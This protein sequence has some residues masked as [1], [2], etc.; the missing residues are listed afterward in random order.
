MAKKGIKKKLWQGISLTLS[1]LCVLSLGGYQIAMGQSAAINH[2]LGI[3]DSNSVLSD[4]E[5]YQYF[6]SDY[7]ADEYELLEKDYLAKAEEVEGEGIVLLANK[8][9]ALPLAGNEK[10]SC[11][12]MG[13]VA[14]NYA[15]SGSSASNTSGYD[16][17]KTA[18]TG[19]GLS[20]NENLWSMYTGS[21]YGRYKKGTTTYI[22]E[23]PYSEYP[24]SVVDTFSEY[25]TAIVTLARDSG[26][27]SDIIAYGAKCDGED[28]NYLR[29]S[30]QEREVLEELTKLKNN[31]TIKKI[32]VLL[33]S[34][35][36]L[37]VDFM[38]DS[39]IDVDACL[40]VGNVG[41][42]GI[43]AVA[44]VLTGEIVP[45]GKLSDTYLYDN[46]SSPA[47]VSES[48]YNSEKDATYYNFA[49]T[50]TNAEEYGLND[51]QKYYGV[52]AEGIYVGY[53]YY[54]TRYADYV[55]GRENTGEYDYSSDVAYSFGYGKSYTQF[56]FS[57]YEVT[58]NG[59][60]YTVSVNVTNTGDT[61]TGKEVVEVYLQKPY[62]DYD[63]ENG[64]EKAA[65]ELVG[66]AK[67][68]ALA[69]KASQTVTVEVPKSSFKSYDRNGAKTYIVDDGDYYITVGNGAHEAVNN[70]L[71]AQG[72]TTSNTD[73]R[74]DAD[75]EAGLVFT[76]HVDSFDS[77]TYAVSEYTGVE[78][79]NRFDDADL[80]KYD[81]SDTTVTY[82]S[83][84]DWEGTFPKSAVEVAVT[85]KMSVDL[86]SDK[87]I[88]E[89]SEAVI[90]TYGAKN[91]LNLAMMRGKTYDDPDWDKLLD[92]MTYEDQS[93]LL[94]NAQMTTVS[95]ASVGK[96]DTQE[97]DGPTGIADS[98]AS[99]SFPSEGIWASSFNDELIGEVGALL[100]EDAIANGYSGIYANGVN[101]HRTPYGGRSHEYFSEDSFLT[102]M[103]AVAEIKGMQAKGV[104]A[105]VK[106]IAFN[107]QEAQRNGICVWLNEQE[108]REIMLVPFEYA[109]TVKNGNAHA[110]MSSFSRVGTDWAGADKDLLFNVMH[111][112]WDFDGYCITDMASSNGALYMTYQDGILLG[113]DCFLG[114]GSTT[115]LDSFKT[116]AT[117]SQ[118]MREASH[119]ILYVTANFSRAM[120]GISPDTVIVAANWWWK[121]LIIVLVSVL[122][123]LSAGSAALWIAGEVKST[124][125]E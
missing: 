1:S 10:V 85:D 86:A 33:N 103:A 111:G 110:V 46:L 94:S 114:S 123:V 50:Y 92:Q 37:Q 18:L 65:V 48:V 100:A 27:G 31:G 61:Y 125:K 105:N 81:G 13:S 74:M 106:H 38:N 89:D 80:N 120:N 44:K 75:G 63:I 2:A 68:E 71:A 23:M 54:E 64:V 118:R 30:A 95:V 29:L 8:N 43:H 83:R 73:G 3:S 93:Y 9:N 32:I 124:K 77:T 98:K 55:A 121:T 112:E 122:A 34:S 14:F 119:R 84:N 87:P 22:N 58:D 36:T 20:V 116:S 16:D 51:T 113:T 88:V 15:S 101:I 41:K 12:M 4:D 69:P 59:D 17:L 72:F 49:Q 104:V 5:A 7:C 26:E 6:K 39:A 35:A 96:P 90:P 42:S 99:L 66:Y 91:G 108:A 115:A 70:I 24:S 62:T 102:A 40:W 11:F 117:Y 97:N 53:R 28:G 79:T 107:D 60:S 21:S 52:Y 56:D 82:V 57:D 67:T 19:A 47:M 109:L 78:I 76:A 45:S 25:G